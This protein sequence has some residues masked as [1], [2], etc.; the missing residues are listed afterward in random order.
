MST[1][2]NNSQLAS[3]DEAR[4]LR[5]FLGSRLG[6][7]VL[8][9]DDEH[10]IQTVS[11]PAMPWMPPTPQVPGIYVPTWEGGPAGFQIPSDGN[12]KFLHFRL[13]NGAEGMNVGLIIDKFSRYPN[14]AEYVL[15]ALADEAN[16]MA[17][18]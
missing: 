17:K 12:R 4:A 16:S 6:G 5:T 2:F 10:G 3:Y 18:K 15:R 11:N 9:G 7:G 1:L 14:S 8:D 13:K